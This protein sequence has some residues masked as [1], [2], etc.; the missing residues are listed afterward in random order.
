MHSL[1]PWDVHCKPREPHLLSMQ[2][3]LSEPLA[4][5]QRH[6]PSLPCQH[7]HKQYCIHPLYSS[8][9]WLCLS[10]KLDKHH[11]LPP[12]HVPRRFGLKLHCLC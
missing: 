12:G 11:C 8:S 3:R 9:I 7:L 10:S 5:E 6:L 2:A 1:Q 4:G